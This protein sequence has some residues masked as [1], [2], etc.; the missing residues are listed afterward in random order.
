MS[1]WLKVVIAVASALLVGLI[2]GY[3]WGVSGKGELEVAAQ[4]ARAKMSAAEL[5]ARASGAQADTAKKASSR[6]LALLRGKEELFRALLELKAS[7]FGLA[8]QHLGYANRQFKKA[9][10]SSSSTL[11][12]RIEGIR[13]DL[14][15]AHAKAL[16]LE[17]VAQVLVES[18][19]T[20][21]HQ[22]PGAR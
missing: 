15:A 7:N 17:P 16:S 19:I 11:R 13:K 1:D 4:R 22:L 20:E 2:A 3:I 12:G 10:A 6:R 8:G 9:S 5:R 21:A 14:G 18:L